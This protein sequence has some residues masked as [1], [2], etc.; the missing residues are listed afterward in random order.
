VKKNYFVDV[1][2][3]PVLSHNEIQDLFVKYQELGMDN[4]E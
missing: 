2:K 1:S 3:Y 4:P